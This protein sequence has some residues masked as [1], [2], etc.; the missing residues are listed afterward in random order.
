MSLLADGRDQQA[1]PQHRGISNR[2]SLIRGQSTSA[3]RGGRGRAKR[4]S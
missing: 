3:G 4:H 1:S 2:G